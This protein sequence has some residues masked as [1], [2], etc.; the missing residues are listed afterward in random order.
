[1][2]FL[3]GFCRWFF[4]LMEYC[5]VTTLMG[6]LGENRRNAVIRRRGAAVVAEDGLKHVEEYVEEDVG[7][8]PLGGEG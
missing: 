4:G 7:G 2:R 3:I 6:I 1:L 5:F 8:A